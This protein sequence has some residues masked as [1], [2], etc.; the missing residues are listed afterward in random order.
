[1]LGVSVGAEHRF[2]DLIAVQA[3]DSCPVCGGKLGHTPGIE[4][5]HIFQLGER[6]SKPLNANFLDE[7]GKAKPYVMGTYGIGVSRL[8]AAAIEQHHDDKGCKWPIAIAPYHVDLIAGN[9]KDEAQKTLAEGLYDKLQ[10]AKIEVIFDDRPAGFGV[11]MNDYELIGFPFALIAG[12]KAADGIVE[13]AV[14]ESGER[15]EMAADEA[16]AWL[17]RQCR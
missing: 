5:G 10:K 12:K 8:M 11:K 13:I 3:G 16:V 2:A 7:N 15:L 6:Y 9:L 1:M 17:E 4:V 14:R